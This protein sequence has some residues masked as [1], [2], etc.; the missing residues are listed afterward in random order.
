MAAGIRQRHS[1]RCKGGRCQ[2]PWEAFVYSKRDGKTRETFPTQSAAKAWRNDASMAVRKML[3][4][5]P[6]TITVE[7]AAEAW[8]EGARAGWI[9]N[10]SS[11]PYKPAAIR[12]YE[13]SL[14]LRVKPALGSMRLSTV[15]RNHLQDLVD[16]LMAEACEPSTIVVTITSLR[17]IYKRALARGDVA[18]NPATGLQLPAVRGRRSRIAS[19][20]ECAKLLDALPVRDRALWA[21]AMFAGLR[22]GELMALRIEDI[23]MGRGVIDVRRGWDTLEGEITTK[24]GR[25]RKVPIAAA[26]RDYLD[27]HLLGLDWSEGL[28]FGVTA[29]SPF[30]G[31]PLMKRAGRAWEAAALKRIT[32]HECRH[33]FASLMIAAGVNAKALSTYM[34][35]ANISITFDH[36]G[37]LMPGSED[38]AAGMLDSYLARRTPDSR[39]SQSFDAAL[40]SSRQRA[41]QG[42]IYRSELQ[43]IAPYEGIAR[44]VVGRRQALGLTRRELA[45]RA[46]MSLSAISRI[47]SGQHPASV[48]TLRRLAEA[49]E[50]ELVVGFDGQPAQIG[51]SELVAVS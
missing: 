41:Q 37:H 28:V 1:R 6:T 29:V 5:V 16:G 51:E 8:L 31:T 22:R 46:G 34:G 17:V 38:E 20:Q 11:D 23:S 44:M 50:V 48:T 10:R 25:E 27:A 12:A 30:N 15:T 26:L 45:T 42:A 47:E 18:V 43:R 13:A 35:H 14:R 9:R 49:F 36:Y 40:Q 21:T 2:C 39:R 24:S 7:E 3:L 19:P 32:L 4:R 33:T